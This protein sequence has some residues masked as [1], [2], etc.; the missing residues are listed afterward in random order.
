[1]AKRG[2][3]SKWDTHVLPNLDRIPKWRRDGMTD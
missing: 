1:M 2:R 3:K